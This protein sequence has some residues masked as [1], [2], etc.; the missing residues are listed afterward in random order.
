MV[1]QSVSV[2]G[3]VKVVSDSP[4][5]VA[6]ELADKINKYVDVNTAR[7]TEYWLTLYS[8]CL[9]AANGWDVEQILKQRQL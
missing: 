8:Q 6:L 4:Q 2:S 7:S 5:R 9:K 1:D 3:P